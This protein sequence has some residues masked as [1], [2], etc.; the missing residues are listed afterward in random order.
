MNYKRSAIKMFQK[1]NYEICQI[2]LSLAYEK[3]PDDE[4]VFLMNLCQ[5]AKKSEKEAIILFE[6]FK[7]SKDR[8]KKIKEFEALIDFGIDENFKSDEFLPQDNIISYND[9]IKIVEKTGNFKE[10]FENVMFCTKVLLSDREDILEFINY[11]ADNGYKDIGLNYLE[12]A[13]QIFCGD[14]RIDEVSK[15][16]NEN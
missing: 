3:K 12:F 5:M 13:A 1:G 2:M 11:L 7:S 6:Y 10:V 15:K 14:V 16:L 4:I 9:F 8:L